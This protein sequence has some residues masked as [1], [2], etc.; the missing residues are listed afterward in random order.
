MLHKMCCLIFFFKIKTVIETYTYLFF[1]PYAY[2]DS[3][4]ALS[5]V[6][7][8]AYNKVAQNTVGVGSFVF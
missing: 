7:L 4:K 3:C 8:V 2:I 1:D 5:V 6:S